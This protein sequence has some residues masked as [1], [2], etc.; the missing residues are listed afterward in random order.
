MLSRG[1]KLLLE[2]YGRLGG[3]R[4]I[5]HMGNRRKRVGG[6]KGVQ[7]NLC[8]RESSERMVK[9][10]R[11]V[12]LTWSR[13]SVETQMRTVVESSTSVTSCRGV[14]SNRN[15]KHRRSSL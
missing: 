11:E 9:I 6:R 12:F 15:I 14:V 5:G 10:E 4:E 8:L 2:L 13:V 1:D 3:S 7:Y